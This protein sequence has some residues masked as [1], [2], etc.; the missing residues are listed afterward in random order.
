MQERGSLPLTPNPLPL[1]P[2]PTPTPTPNPQPLQVAVWSTVPKILA[3]HTTP[4]H[5]STQA[6]TEFPTTN[7]F[8]MAIVTSNQVRQNN[9]PNHN[10]P[11]PRL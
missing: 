1:I 3:E 8:E 2:T 5:P 9:H 7:F 11:Q 10:L 4:L 6:N